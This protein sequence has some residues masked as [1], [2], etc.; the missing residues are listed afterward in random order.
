[1]FASIVSMLT[2]ARL[3]AQLDDQH[4]VSRPTVSSDDWRAQSHYG[5]R[6]ERRAT[7]ISARQQRKRRNI[8]RDRIGD[9]RF[10]K[11]LA[12]RFEMNR[13]DRRFFTKCVGA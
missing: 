5:P 12:A 6:A 7:G 9:R 11:L 4:R 10:Y 13:N 2:G 3:H 8:N 1:M